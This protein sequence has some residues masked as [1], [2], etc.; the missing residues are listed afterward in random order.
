LITLGRS[1]IS[2]TELQT[3]V[4]LLALTQRRSLWVFVTVEIQRGGRRFDGC[5]AS[6]IEWPQ[7]RKYDDH[8]LRQ[9]DM[10]TTA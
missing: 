4:A 2:A 1:I 6:R 7:V 3:F 9:A 8:A 5:T 10:K